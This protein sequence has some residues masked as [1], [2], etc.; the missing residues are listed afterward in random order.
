[1]GKL[2]FVFEEDMPTVSIWR[3]IFTHLKHYPKIV[4]DFMYLSDIKTEL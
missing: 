1:M 4:S 2:L 3:D